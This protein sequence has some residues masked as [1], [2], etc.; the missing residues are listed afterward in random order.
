MR[1]SE[2]PSG[3]SSLPVLVLVGL[4]LAACSS[5]SPRANPASP[6]SPVPARTNVEAPPPPPPPPPAEPLTVVIEESHEEAPPP[7]L[8]EASRLARERKRDAPPPSVVITNKNLA[9]YA[10]RGSLTVAPPK[11]KDES[12]TAVPVDARDEKYWRSGVLRLR[13]SW[14]EAHDERIALE[15]DAE[16][17]RFRFYAERDVRFRDAEVKPVWD[18]TLDRLTEVRLDIERLQAELDAFLEEGRRAG[19]LPGW[20]DEGIELEPAERPQRPVKDLEEYE[21]K[22]PEIIDEG[23]QPR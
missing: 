23:S 8:L 12:A 16:Q 2:A 10:K 11:A 9:E 7:S 22:D 3:R 20:L 5:S 21:V 1:T 17:L 13:Q 4:A 18:R 15:K 19:A 14:R 6:A